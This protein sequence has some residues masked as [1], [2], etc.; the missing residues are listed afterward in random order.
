MIMFLLAALGGLAAWKGL[1]SPS[2]AVVSPG[3]NT[4][5][6]LASRPGSG[7]ELQRRDGQLT[8]PSGSTP[9]VGMTGIR[10]VVYQV[11]QGIQPAPSQRNNASHYVM[12]AIP[13]PLISPAKPVSPGS[14]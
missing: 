11:P 14:I 4:G 5:Q 1:N 10:P 2:G 7:D 3:I 8:P 13:A 12:P 9:A 6:S